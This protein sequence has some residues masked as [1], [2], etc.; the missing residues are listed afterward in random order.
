MA[1]RMRKRTPDGPRVLMAGDAADLPAIRG[2]LAEC[3]PGASG[4]VFIEVLSPLQMVHLDAPAGIGVH[5]LFRERV[6]T[7]IAV[8][9]EALVGAVDAWLDEWMRADGGVRIEIWLGARS[10]TLVNSYA[11]DLEHELAAAS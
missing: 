5:W 11:R 1:S 10:S 3:E 4:V 9:G 6:R 7:G 8:R 2:R